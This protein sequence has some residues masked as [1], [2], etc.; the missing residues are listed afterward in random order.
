MALRT[1]HMG[2]PVKG[3]KLIVV[4]E[5]R[6]VTKTGIHPLFLAIIS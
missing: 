5:E 2:V 3:D 4:D 6:M 1:M